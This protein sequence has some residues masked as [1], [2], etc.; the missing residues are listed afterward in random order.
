MIE[1]GEYY[2]DEMIRVDDV[3]GV[4]VGKSGSGMIY[5]L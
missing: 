1:L 5:D 3:I 2:S 4:G